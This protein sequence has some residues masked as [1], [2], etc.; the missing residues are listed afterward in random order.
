M[1]DIKRQLLLGWHFDFAGKHALGKRA[2]R[3]VPEHLSDAAKLVNETGHAG[4]RR[5]DHWPTRFYAAKN[6]IRQVLMRSSGSLET[7]RHS[8]HLRAGSRRDLSRLEGQIV[9]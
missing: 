5:A 3:V 2:A 1:P 6:C 4:I 7:S 9:W 8:S